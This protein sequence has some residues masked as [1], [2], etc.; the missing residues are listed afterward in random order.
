MHDL[1]GQP[2][3]LHLDRDGLPAGHDRHAPPLWGKLSDLFSKKLLVQVALVVYVAGSA[4]AGLS[5]S[6]SMLI[7]CSRRPGHRRRRALS[8]LA[9][10]VM[11]AM[12]SPRERGRYSGYRL[13]DFAVRHP[14][15]ARCSGAASSPTPA[16]WAGAGASTSA[17]PLP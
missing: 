15:A 16:G 7:T 11:A 14:S 3:R 1:H 2:V 17:C 9:Q 13:R 8:A 12:I 10:I 5:Q 6:T 4:L